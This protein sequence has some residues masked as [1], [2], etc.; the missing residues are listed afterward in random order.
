MPKTPPGLTFA[1]IAFAL[2]AFAAGSVL[3]HTA[4]A[5]PAEVEDTVQEVRPAP[6]PVGVH[7][8]LGLAAD[9]ILPREV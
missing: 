1:G 8:D 3:E 9:C 7:V 4:A 2:A 6:A 5:A